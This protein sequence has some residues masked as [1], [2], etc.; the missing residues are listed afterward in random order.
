MM[1]KYLGPLPKNDPLH[2][3]LKNEILPELRRGANGGDFQ[4]YQLAGSND[5]YLYH[6]QASG[7]RVVGKFFLSAHKRD[8]AAAARKMSRE[9]ENL[10]RLRQ[11]G[12]AAA[13]HY[14]VRPLG[15]NKGLNC[16]LVVEYQGGELFSDI[17]LAAIYRGAGQRLYRKLTALAY[18]LA[19]LHNRSALG[20]RVDFNN[21]CVY[22]DRLVTRLATKHLLGQEEVFEL[23]WLRGQWYGQK[24]MWQDQR[25]LVHGDATPDNFLLGSG[26]EVVAFDLERAKW[27]DRVFD[28]GRIAGELKHFFLQ[29]T[30]DAQA[31]E[32]FIGHFLWEYACHFPDRHRA[33]Q[34]ITARIPFHLGLTLLRIARNSWIEPSYRPLLLAE[35]KNNL[36]RFV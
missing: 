2:Y 15:C 30:G 25:V 28:V 32:P 7:Q 13:P 26:L 34:S 14:V 35:A 6:D 10:Q 20:E 4:V 3:Y 5:V 19:S 29:A 23:Q 17:I 16:V 27:A 31:A 9:Y 1:K 24:R 21:D 18:F 33:F 36:R 12:F 11:H 8:Q 22:M